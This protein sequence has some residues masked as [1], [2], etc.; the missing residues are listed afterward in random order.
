MSDADGAVVWHDGSYPCKYALVTIDG[1]VWNWTSSAWEP[2]PATPLP[3][4]L[5]A[6][7]RYKLGPA[8]WSQDVVPPEILKAGQ[9]QVLAFAV[10]GTG[11]PSSFVGSSGLT[12][13][14]LGLTL[15][16]ASQ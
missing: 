8:S 9:V 10:D 6:M 2:L 5:K 7:T 16:T 1:R 11:K 4:H 15:F 13:A 14:T 12:G 3:D